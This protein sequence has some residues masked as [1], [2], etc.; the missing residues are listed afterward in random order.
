MITCYDTSR[1]EE[2]YIRVYILAESRRCIHYEIEEGDT[3][4]A[5]CISLSRENSCTLQPHGPESGCGGTADRPYS[6]SDPT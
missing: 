6:V 5:M 1:C 2:W 4:V 3:Y